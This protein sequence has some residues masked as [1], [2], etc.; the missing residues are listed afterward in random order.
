MAGGLVVAAVGCV[1]LA[2]GP[3]NKD[4]F[5]EAPRVESDVDDSLVISVDDLLLYAFK[6]EKTLWESVLPHVPL[7]M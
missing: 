3:G 1:L 4:G 5:V 7:F 6:K 2:S